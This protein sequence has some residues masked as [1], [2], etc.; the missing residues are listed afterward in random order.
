MHA[1]LSKAQVEPQISQGKERTGPRVRWQHRSSKAPGH[2]RN[3]SSAHTLACRSEEAGR[4]GRQS[5]DSPPAPEGNPLHLPGRLLSAL[6]GLVSRSYRARGSGRFH[7]LFTKDAADASQGPRVGCDGHTPQGQ[8]AGHA[9]HA[10]SSVREEERRHSGSGTVAKG[11]SAALFPPENAGQGSHR[12]N[13]TL[14]GHMSCCGF[15]GAASAFGVR[16]G[17][18]GGPVRSPGDVT[19]L[20]DRLCSVWFHDR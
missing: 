8:G 9:P 4:C 7:V 14:S 11:T 5:R 20:A 1:R 18:R 17:R 19:Q 6:K 15:A 2:L 12:E 3:P 10:A 16:E 13:T